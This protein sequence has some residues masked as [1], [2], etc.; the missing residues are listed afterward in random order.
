MKLEQNFKGK[1]NKQKNNDFQ[2]CNIKE[3]SFRMRKCVWGT[4]WLKIKM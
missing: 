2:R 3:R 4:S 1:T